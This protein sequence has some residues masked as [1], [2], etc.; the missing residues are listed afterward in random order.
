MDWRSLETDRSFQL[1][2]ARPRTESE[3]R[4][5][6]NNAY[7][8]IKVAVALAGAFG[9]TVNDLPLTL[10]VSWFEQKAVA[11]L[12]TLLALGV[13]GITV[14][15]N[16]PAFFSKNVFEVLKQQYDLRLTSKDP[17]ADVEHLASNKF[18]LERI[19][20]DGAEKHEQL[21]PHRSTDDLREGRD[22]D[23]T[24]RHERSELP[25]AE[26]VSGDCQLVCGQF[27]TYRQDLFD[28]HRLRMAGNRDQRKFIDRFER[29]Q[30]YAAGS[31]DPASDHPFANL[32]LAAGAL[33]ICKDQLG[34]GKLR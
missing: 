18:L 11:V 17:E 2:S 1:N 29:I 4:R 9:C 12:L 20:S 26:I 32:L 16:P 13:K 28:I 34:A 7:S 22:V 6:C 8:A 31:I 15:P 21:Q 27:L 24:T 23:A 14:G 25:G 30:Q 19:L 3:A 10:V 5:Q 33:G